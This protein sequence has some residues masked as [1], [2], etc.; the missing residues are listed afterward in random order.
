MQ[1][2]ALT[3]VS[4]LIGGSTAFAASPVSSAKICKREFTHDLI[5]CVVTSFFA[6]PKTRIEKLK[7]CVQAAKVE[8]F[9][10]LQPSDPGPSPCEVSCQANYDANLVTCQNTFD[11][12]VCGGNVACENFYQ[13]ERANCISGEVDTLNA[14][15]QTCAQ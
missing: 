6:K 11:P 10:C 13:Q 9:A 4:F 15:N 8:K 1:L 7:T 12:A 14:C 5:K 2:F 3:F